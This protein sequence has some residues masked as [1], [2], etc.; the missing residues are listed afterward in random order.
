MQVVFGDA[1]RTLMAVLIMIST[2]GCNVGLIL[3]GARVS[4]AMAQDGLF[5]RGVGSLDPVHHTPKAA[6]WVQCL[7]TCVLAMSGTYSQLLDYVIF[8]AVLFFFLTCVALVRLRFTRPDLE[9]PV[10]TFAWPQ[11]PAAYLLATGTLLVVLLVRKPL[12]TWPGVFIVALGIPVYFIWR[13]LGAGS[14]ENAREV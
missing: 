3:A 10:G 2:F 9:R 7:W 5:F 13:K 11:L 4:W 14:M 8:A 12:Y 6:L 1:G